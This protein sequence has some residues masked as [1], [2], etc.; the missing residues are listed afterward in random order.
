VEELPKKLEGIDVKRSLTVAQLDAAAVPSRHQQGERDEE[1][2]YQQPS[3]PLRQPPVNGQRARAG[4]PAGER[5][6][7]FGSLLFH[8]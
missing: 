8:E 5:R 6:R 1:R 2:R 3:P 4:R 7:T